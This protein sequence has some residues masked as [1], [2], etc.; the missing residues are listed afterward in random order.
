MTQGS[1][2]DDGINGKLSNLTGGKTLGTLFI[3]LFVFTHFYINQ[4]VI[5]IN[6]LSLFSVIIGA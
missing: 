3:F 1:L 2:A 6:G 5:I 4:L